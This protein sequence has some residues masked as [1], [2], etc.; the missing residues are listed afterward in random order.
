[1]L[2]FGFGLFFF[3]ALYPFTNLQRAFPLGGTMSYYTWLGTG[4]LSDIKRQN[5]DFS[6][7]DYIHN[8]ATDNSQR[9]PLMC[10]TVFLLLVEPHFRP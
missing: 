2:G 1:L 5:G 10:C 8:G 7:V 6:I 3:P 4:N 9:Q